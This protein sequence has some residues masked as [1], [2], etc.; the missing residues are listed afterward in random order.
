MKSSQKKPNIKSGLD[1][2]PPFQNLLTLCIPKFKF[3][4]DDENSKIM[5]VYCKIPVGWPLA[6]MK[7]G[8]DATKLVRKPI[9][10]SRRIIYVKTDAYIRIF[11]LEGRTIKHWNVFGFQN[12][13]SAVLDYYNYRTSCRMIKHI[14][15][16]LKEQ[17]IYASKSRLK[18]IK[19]F[20]TQMHC[21]S[22][23]YKLNKIFM[24]KISIPLT[25]SPSLE[26]ME[27]VTDFLILDWVD[28]V[29]PTVL[30]GLILDFYDWKQFQLERKYSNEREFLYCKCSLKFDWIS[31]TTRMHHVCFEVGNNVCCM[32]DQGHVC[33]SGNR[34]RR[35]HAKQNLYCDNVTDQRLDYSQ[36][37]K[38]EQ[39]IDELQQNA[40]ED[41]N[42][43]HFRGYISYL[44]CRDCPRF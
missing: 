4:W 41:Y 13:I 20:F 6:K 30:V 11:I 2:S 39:Y 32:Y 17:N 26:K 31:R 22:Y 40:D 27:R 3:K 12:Y 42:L 21:M 24:K 10:W 8:F 9:V 34:G 18:Q 37:E 43:E 23:C 35:R 29:I 1:E 5:D 19:I 33:I 14:Y 15:R 38:A 36:W 25:K 7:C 44:W 28:E 16:C